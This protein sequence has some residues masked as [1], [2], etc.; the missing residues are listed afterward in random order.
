MKKI[1][2]ILAAVMASAMVLGMSMTTM[3]AETTSVTITVDNAENATLY[4]DQI[5]YANTGAPYGWEYT[6]NYKEAFT[7]LDIDDLI[8]IAQGSENGN[9]TT[10][11][12]TTSSEL[13]AILEDIRETV[14][15]QGTELVAG[16]NDFEVSLSG[17]YVVV[18]TNSDYTYTPTLVYVPHNSTDDIQVATKGAKNQVVKDVDNNGQSVSAGD[19]IEYTVTFE[20]PYIAANYTDATFKITDTLT[21]GTLY[22]DATHNVS[23]TP[24]TSDHYSVT[25]NN[26]DR[27]LTID[28]TNY[29]RSKAG[30]AVT[31]T[32]YVKVDNDIADKGSLSNKVTS[33][34]DLTTEPGDEI[35]TEYTVVSKPVNATI[36]KVDAET[37][38]KLPGS[39]FAIYEGIASDDTSDT[40]ISIMADAENTDGITLPDEYQDDAD[41]LEADG[42]A[43][44]T[45][46]FSGLNATKDYYVVEIIAPEGYQID[47]I[48]HQLIKGGLKSDNEETNGNTIT[49]TYEYYD[50][51][52]NENGSNNITNTKLSSLPSTGGIG[53]TI[54]TVG[55][56]VI[57]IAAAGLFFASRRKSS[58]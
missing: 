41:L 7:N 37:S 21:N 14:M 57:M 3:A 42:T 4:Y 48:N 58:K 29:D 15:N 51:K 31:I 53:T 34:L 47:G 49:K 33:D 6:E 5:A 32:Y 39:V 23:I 36:D 2:K 8:N 17:L 30:T 44:G 25:G 20:Y 46:T 54:F 18:P 22:I 24:I 1:K 10:G 27:T 11:A 28:F 12:L 38:T 40:L 9:A 43:N 16:D 52:V 13:A 56:C 55:G 50:F 26:G 45:I 19:I 35:E